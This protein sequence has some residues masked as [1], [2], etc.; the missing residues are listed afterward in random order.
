MARIQTETGVR[1]V[2]TDTYKGRTIEVVTGYEIRSDKWPFHV[3]I[4]G[5]K[6]V[7]QFIADRMDEAFDGGFQI[8]ESEIDRT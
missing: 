6:V 7:G 1:N 2:Q 5:H 3:Y 8:A 4:D